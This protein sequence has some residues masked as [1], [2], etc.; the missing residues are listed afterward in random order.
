MKNRF[1]RDNK[2]KVFIFWTQQVDLDLSLI[3]QRIFTSDSRY[4]SKFVRAVIIMGKLL[5]RIA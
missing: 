5:C 2:M 1:D 3:A 4:I